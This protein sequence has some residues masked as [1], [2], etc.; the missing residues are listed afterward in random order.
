MVFYIEISRRERNLTRN[1]LHAT[2]Y[3]KNKQ[4]P[5]KSIVVDA[6]ML[7]MFYIFAINLCK[8]LNFI[9]TKTY[10]L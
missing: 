10:L 2:L 4:V 3:E 9:F 1:I 8:E 6:Y 5:K 7:S